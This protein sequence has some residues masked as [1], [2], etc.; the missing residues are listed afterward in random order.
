M[1]KYE[2]NEALEAL[3]M[4]YALSEAGIDYTIAYGHSGKQINVRDCPFCGNSKYKVYINANTGLGNCFAGSCGQRTF[5]KWQFLKE[6]WDL[7][8]R[9]TH[10]KIEA[11]ARDQ[12][13]RPKVAPKRFVLKDLELPPSTPVAEL[14]AMPRYLQGRGIDASVASHFDL[15][16]CDSGT[17]EVKDPEGRTMR[18]DYSKRIIIPIYKADGTLVSFQGRDATGTSEK[19]Y[20]FPPMYSSTGSQLYNIQNWQDGMDAVVITEGPFDAI[21]V[22]KALK[23]NK[24]AKT[25]ATASFGMSFTASNA[26]QD[27]QIN[28]LLELKARGLKVVYV[29][30]DN[31]PIALKNA[32]AA[33]RKIIRYGFVAKLCVLKDAKDP[34]EATP[35]QIMEALQGAHTIGSDLQAMMIERKLAI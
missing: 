34:G 28:R 22:Y 27:D 8:P 17:F 10:A 12:G 23:T 4:E 18:Q 2:P 35:D 26:G 13:Y 19:R 29:M 7:G 20:L 14:P 24:I 25:L 9:D 1:T 11:L 32:I 33:C 6:I 5:N 31:E 30:W 16:Y 21:G 15:R 3:D